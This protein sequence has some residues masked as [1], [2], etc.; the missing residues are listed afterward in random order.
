MFVVFHPAHG[1][2]FK[3]IGTRDSANVGP[4]SS[5]DRRVLKACGLCSRRPNESGCFHIGV[6]WPAIVRRKQ[7]A[8]VV[9]CG[10]FLLDAALLSVETAGYS[11]PSRKADWAS[12]WVHDTF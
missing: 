8:S 3:S 6:T 7:N 5:A 11:H 9:P 2:S 10:D 4:A 1:K 12:G